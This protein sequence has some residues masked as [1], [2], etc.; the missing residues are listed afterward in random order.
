MFAVLLSRSFVVYI[1]LVYLKNKIKFIKKTLAGLK[2]RQ[3]FLNRKQFCPIGVKYEI[4][5]VSD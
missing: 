5:V 3:K 4:L 1:T 2:E